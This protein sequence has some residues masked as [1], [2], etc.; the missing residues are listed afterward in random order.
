MP[1][2]EHEQDGH[3]DQYNEHLDDEPFRGGEF[4]TYGGH[5]DKPKHCENH[6]GCEPKHPL[7][8]N[9]ANDIVGSTRQL[10]RPMN[11]IEIGT[12]PS[13]QSYSYEP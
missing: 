10:R 6:C 13:R 11:A 9:R 2:R 3:G 7:N 12:D 1:H 8:D 5:Y 4:G